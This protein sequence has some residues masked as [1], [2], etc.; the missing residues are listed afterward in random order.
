MCSDVFCLLVCKI[1]SCL[2]W[3]QIY[4]AKAKTVQTLYL[5]RFTLNMILSICLIFTFVWLICTLFV[6]AWMS[7]WPSSFL[8]PPAKQ[9]QNCTK[10]KSTLGKRSFPSFSLFFTSMTDLLCHF[11]LVSHN[12]VSPILNVYAIIIQDTE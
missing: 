6:I 12:F 7:I 2:L 4:V 8:T 1:N 5:K 10:N 3:T 9:T 11:D